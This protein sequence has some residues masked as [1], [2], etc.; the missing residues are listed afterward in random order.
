MRRVE[1][2][3][4]LSSSQPCLL[5]PHTKGKSALGTSSGAIVLLR[6]FYLNHLKLTLFSLDVLILHILI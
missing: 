4:Q 2:A 3:S 1:V 6:L 5:C